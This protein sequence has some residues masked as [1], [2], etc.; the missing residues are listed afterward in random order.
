MARGQDC[1]FGSG[2]KFSDSQSQCKDRIKLCRL[3]NLAMCIAQ[4]AAAFFTVLRWLHI[5]NV[6]LGL[7][8]QGAKHSSPQFI[9]LGLGG[10]SVLVVT[11]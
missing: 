3:L 11:G 8:F 7:R 1:P 9:V 2:P 5:S 6:P 10:L 4:A